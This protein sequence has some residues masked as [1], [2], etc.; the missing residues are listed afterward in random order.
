M[1]IKVQRLGSGNEQAHTK[2][3]EFWHMAGKIAAP[4]FDVQQR[5]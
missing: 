4:A 5:R 3:I 1:K 2:D